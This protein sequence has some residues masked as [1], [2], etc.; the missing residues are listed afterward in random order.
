[1]IGKTVSHYRILEKLGQGGM[2]EV[3]P[4]EDANL[5]RHV[6]IKVLP[7]EFAHD[8]ER[9]AR[10]QRQAEVI[11]R[12]EAVLRRQVTTLPDP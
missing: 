4:A 6:A 8:A 12:P 3:Y 5:H 7:D 2:G 11:L 1:M 9:L 10:F